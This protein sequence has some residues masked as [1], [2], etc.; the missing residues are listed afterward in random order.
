MEEKMI[1]N[2]YF[3]VPSEIKDRAELLDE[4][5]VD[6]VIPIFN[7]NY[8]W[9]RNLYNYYEHIPINK[10]IIGDGGCTDDSLEIL[11]KF[12]RVE[13]VDQS[14]YNSLGY[15]IVDLVSHVETEW[16]VYLHADVFLPDGWFESMVAKRGN[17][18]FYEC[19]QQSTMLVEYPTYDYSK[20]ERAY[21]CSQMGKKEAFK[22]IIEIIDDDYLYRNEDII[23][24]ELIDKHGFKYGRNMNTYVYHQIMNKKGEKEPD[25]EKVEISRK[26]SEDW[27]KR[28]WNMQA[29]G[30]IKYLEP[31][32]KYLIDTVN[33][34]LYRLNELGVLKWGEFKSWVSETNPAWLKHINAKGSL[35]QQVKNF[36]KKIIK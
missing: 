15:S 36:I 10:L 26:V 34:S 19:K 20:V 35:K 2:E 11:K 12:P 21:S 8:L 17:F 7:T 27:E 5:R 31:D 1:F 4:E 3:N 23:I 22:K 9:E 25:F 33:I 6:V 13:V 30:V 29:R 16:F 32:K 28:T 24:A 14:S 18:D